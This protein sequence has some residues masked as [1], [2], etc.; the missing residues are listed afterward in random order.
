M[1]AARLGGYIGCHGA[2]TLLW[3]PYVSRRLMR[4]SGFEIDMYV[5]CPYSGQERSNFAEIRFIPTQFIKGH[6][7]TVRFSNIEF[8]FWP[9]LC[10][11]FVVEWKP[12]WKTVKSD[13]ICDTIFNMYSLGWISVSHSGKISYAHDF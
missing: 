9:V 11:D 4:N 3:T 6:S 5:L 13:E 12:R 8:D 1:G 2:A 7:F 10:Y